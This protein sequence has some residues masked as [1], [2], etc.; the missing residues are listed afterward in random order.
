MATKTQ[1]QKAPCSQ[2]FCTI[3]YPLQDGTKSTT[4]LH[5][6]VDPS[7]MTFFPPKGDVAT[8]SLWSTTVGWWWHAEGTT[9]TSKAFG[10]LASLGAVGKM[11]GLTMQH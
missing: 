5:P 8:P 1:N 6:M 11:N 7:N 9:S 4:V 2:T 3:H 10:L